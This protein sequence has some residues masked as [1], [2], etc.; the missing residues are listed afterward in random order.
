MDIDP[1]VT[2]GLVNRAVRSGERDGTPTRTIMTQRTFAADQAD[3]WDALTNAD[4]IQRWFL[5]VSGTLEIGGRYQLEGNAAGVVESCTEPDSFSVTWEFGGSTSWLTV[6]LAPAAD[7]TA[8]DAAHEA[9]VDPDFWTQYGPGATGLGWDLAVAALG[10]HLATGEAFGPTAEA[11][12]CASAEG[13]V[14]LRSA[15]TGWADAAVA[16]GDDVEPARLAA[17]RSVTLY[18]PPS[19]YLVGVRNRS[20]GSDIR[21]VGCQVVE[22]N[23]HHFQLTLESVHHEL[24]CGLRPHLHRCAATRTRCRT[25]PPACAV[26]RRLR[27]WP[28]RNRRA[29]Q[30]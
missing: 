13:A 25:S 22:H 2:A 26:R 6:N 29:R 1:L 15:A 23:A 21:E 5:P 8:L 12:F 28:T 14:F 9:P 10:Q 27:T 19:L 18:T 7:G 4:R 24:G 20:L 3:L 30:R 16:D 11:D 17:K